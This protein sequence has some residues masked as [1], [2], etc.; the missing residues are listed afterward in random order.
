MFFA[1]SQRNH[2]RNSSKVAVNFPARDSEWRTQATG[3][4]SDR[5]LWNLEKGP[6]NQRGAARQTSLDLWAAQTALVLARMR[7]V[8]LDL[9]WYGERVP[10]QQFTSIRW[11]RDQSRTNSL[12]LLLKKLKIL[13]WGDQEKNPSLSRHGVLSEE[14]AAKDLSWQSKVRTKLNPAGVR[15]KNTDFHHPFTIPSPSN[16]ASSF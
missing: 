1:E 11:F 4:K 16:L 15:K 9:S 14:F 3:R 5:T 6:A 7:L 10:L 13:A 2:T 8:L 12:C